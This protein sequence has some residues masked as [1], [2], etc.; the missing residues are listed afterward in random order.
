MSWF[1]RIKAGVGKIVS[2]GHNFAGKIRGAALGSVGKI[3]H[4]IHDVQNF[5][6]KIK[7]FAPI[8]TEIVDELSDFIP[9]A[10]VIKKGIGYGLR[11]ADY[12]SDVAESALKTANGTENFIKQ[13]SFQSLKDVMANHD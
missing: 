6:K 2:R 13:P 11:A 1:N 4:T 3:K 12:A 7:D 5:I 8:T 9:G 10:G